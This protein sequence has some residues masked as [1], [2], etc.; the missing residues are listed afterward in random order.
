[1]LTEALSRGAEVHIG[2][3]SGAS[4][5]AEYQI[6]LNDLSD[7]FRLSTIEDFGLREL[8]R[9]SLEFGVTRTIV[10]DAD[11]LARQVASTGS[12]RGSG[13]LSIL[14]MRE[15]AQGRALSPIT[16][17]KTTAKHTLMYRASSVRNVEV[18]V[19]KSA[20]WEGRS[21]FRV[22][23]DPV[24]LECTYLDVAD[25]RSAWGLSS[26]TYWFAVLGAV[27]ERKNVPLVVESLATLSK[28]DYAAGPLGLLIAGSVDGELKSDLLNFRTKCEAAGIEFVVI[29]RTLSNT[30]L[31]AAVAASNCLV[32]AHSNEG[33][34]GLLGKAA[35]AGTRILA[36]GANS[37][38]HDIRSLGDMAEWTPL[39][40]SE[41]KSAMKRALTSG[42]GE[43]KLSANKEMFVEALMPRA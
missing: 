30:E 11:I 7:N 8:E 3:P 4:E 20:T 33:P 13:T 43:P 34:S 36:A 25:V 15:K 42:R 41:L 10:T 24:E 21:L 1:M 16:W 26:G 37:L 17:L 23:K 40:T 18:S 5:S 2:L 27:T 14:I 35:C 28:T 12:W 29:D 6:H 19:L 9:L 31:D 39:K 32:L 38:R 22:A